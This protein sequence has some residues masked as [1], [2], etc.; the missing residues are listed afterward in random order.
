MR[1][2]I[3]SFPHTQ[4]AFN[5]EIVHLIHITFGLRSSQKDSFF[6]VWQK[7]KVLKK[8]QDDFQSSV[9]I[10]ISDITKKCPKGLP[11]VGSIS[12]ASFLTDKTRKR[13][14]KIVSK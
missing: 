14:L 3:Y 13:L 8:I 4:I 2:E 7:A 9:Q 11:L 12:S 6:H 1:W 10:V 5:P